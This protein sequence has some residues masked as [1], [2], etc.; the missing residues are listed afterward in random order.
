MDAPALTVKAL[1]NDLLHVIDLQVAAGEVVCLSGASGSGKS[2]LLRALADL[3]PHQ[4]EVW[5]GDQAQQL[6]PAHEWRQ[7]VRLAPA[8]SQ[9]W[10]DQVSEHFPEDFE[11]SE[12]PLVGLPEA[13]LNWQASRLSSGEKQRLGLLRALA[14]PLEA[15]LLDEPTANLDAATA[16]QVESWLLQ[17]IQEASWPTLWVSHDVQQIQ[18]VSQRAFYLESGQLH[19]HQALEFSHGRD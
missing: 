12:L 16:E 19:A 7:R 4:G 13:A 1:S 17:R 15:L 14:W 11:P 3:D 6:L 5:L 9:W 2:R 18:R 10:M 8:E